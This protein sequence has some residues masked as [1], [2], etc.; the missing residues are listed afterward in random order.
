M[1]PPTFESLLVTRILLLLW[2]LY[3]SWW[4]F[5]IYIIYERETN[6]S[7]KRYKTICGKYNHIYEFEN[8][9]PNDVYR[10]SVY[11]QYY[12]VYIADV[13]EYQHN[14]IINET[15]YRPLCK[16][17]ILQKRKNQMY[18]CGGANNIIIK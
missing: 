4:S 15:I 18:L 13:R 5:C 11:P 10:A 17:I 14:N 1:N 16:R 3:L 6:K 8:E 7:G 2:S 9:E 12:T